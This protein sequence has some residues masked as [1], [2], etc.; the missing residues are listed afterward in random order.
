MGDKQGHPFRGNQWTDAQAGSARTF[1]PVSK[2]DYKH[3]A[4]LIDVWRARAGQADPAAERDF[5]RLQDGWKDMTVLAKEEWEKEKA[6]GATDADYGALYKVIQQRAEARMREQSLQHRELE[7]RAKASQARA[8]VEKALNAPPGS[9]TIEEGTLQVL[10]DLMPDATDA[11]LRRL[12]MALPGSD[13]RV[14]HQGGSTPSPALLLSASGG[15]LLSAERA[16]T[17]ANDGTVVMR[18]IGIEVDPALKGGG[19][20]SVLFAEQVATARK[21]GVG[22][23]TADCARAMDLNGYYTWARLGFDG[24]G[25]IS[26]RREV[27]ISEQ[28]R[29]PE[30]RREWRANGESFDG[31]FSLKPGSYSMRTLQEYKGRN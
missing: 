10:K 18:N 21:M 13:V 17:R 9:V 22:A 25:K 31:T 23:I 4:S 24:T 28:M 5:K 16:I 29:T 14:R 7:P 19:I 2:G 12:V 11:E 15:G 1:S 30:G 27:R 6:K 20:G 3:E 8:A 26:G